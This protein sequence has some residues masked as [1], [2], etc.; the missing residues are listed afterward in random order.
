[1][2]E[3][4]PIKDLT[5]MID[6]A[7]R[8]VT[9]DE[10]VIRGLDKV[11]ME[12]KKGEKAVATIPPE[13]A[14]GSGGLEGTDI[15]VPGG[16]TVTYEVE[17]LEFENAKESYEMDAAEMMAAALKFKEKGNHHFKRQNYEVAIAKYGKAVKYVGSFLLSLSLSLFPFSL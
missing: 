10:Q 14:F 3:T 7:T 2:N 13:H 6:F 15:S 1:M 16:A 11:V 12:M 17:L 9:D 4:D 8:Y 5:L